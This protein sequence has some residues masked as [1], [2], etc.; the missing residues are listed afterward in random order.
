MATPNCTQAPSIGSS[1]TVNAH[2][3]GM[4]WDG[5]DDR[6][7]P[8]NWSQTKKWRVTLLACFMTF[9][10]QINGTAM[11]SAAEQINES[12]HV[13]DENFPHSY[14][15]VFSWTLSGAAAPMIGL[16]LME[17][18]GVRW[19]YM[20]M[21]ACLII[22]IVPQAVAQNFATLIVTRI[23]TGG[24]SATLA[25]ITSGILSDMWRDGRAK[26]FGTSL[27]IWGLLAGLSTGPVIGS[28]ILHFTT[29]RWIFFSQII[30]YS[31]F[32]PVIFVGLPEVRPD[33][34]LARRAR[35]L[36]K[37]TNTKI[38]AEVEK[39]HTSIR[40]IVRETLV[41]PTRM[42][43]TEAV[44]LTFGLWSAFCVGTAFMFTQSI[45]QVYSGLYDWTFYGTGL[46]QVA[47]VIGEIAGLVAS[48]GQDEL[49]FRSARTNV[50]DPGKPI[51]ESRLYLSIPASFLGLAGGL[52]Y[53]A[54]TSYPSIPWIVPTIALGSVGFGMFCSVTAV[55]TYL[56]DAYAKYAAS[57]IA[58][59]A[60]LENI[61][62]AFLPLAT[63]SMYRTLGFHW[64]SSLLGFLALALSFLPVVLF[65]F[66]RKIREKSPFMGESAYEDR[67]MLSDK[68]RARYRSSMG[69]T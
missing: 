5:P 54:W 58:G 47:I 42:L 3:D 50:E 20:M 61:L 2:P 59:A 26:S 67:K 43:C 11:T 23:I 41:R 64:A 33:V 31:V 60:F 4:D 49:Y 27:Y 37:T 21:Y 6:T 14:W 57:A 65:F 9:V 66:G 28:A 56:L 25:N 10:L 53:F 62:A 24:C 39:Q 12:F 38:Y 36:R 15:P 30:F 16:P 63:Q 7:N 19:S 51:P 1:N 40:E 8:F 55:T 34:I 35:T 45:V 22:F 52:F 29:W 48:I 17:H 44:V 68:P 46:V 69:Y 32:F 13:S 18:F